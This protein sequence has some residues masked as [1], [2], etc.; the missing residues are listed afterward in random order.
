VTKTH[1]VLLC[2]SV[3]KLNLFIQLRKSTTCTFKN[4]KW[5]RGYLLFVDA[6]YVD[7]LM[8]H[9]FQCVILIG[10]K[11]EDM[12]NTPNV[13]HIPLWQHGTH[14]L[15]TCWC[16]GCGCGCCGGGGS[17]GGN[18]SL[19][20]WS[21]HCCCVYCHV[22]TWEASQHWVGQQNRVLSSNNVTLQIW[23]TLPIIPPLGGSVLPSQPSTLLSVWW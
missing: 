7:W 4:H 6:L 20:E 19:T 23:F 5:I 2:W 15:T 18:D 22:E 17:G 21:Y 14:A 13:M 10:K 3:C 16:C 8:Q 9:M 12:E 1:V 11:L